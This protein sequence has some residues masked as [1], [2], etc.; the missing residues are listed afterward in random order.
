[1]IYFKKVILSSYTTLQIETALRKYALK[2]KMPLDMDFSSIDIGT[3][4]YFL[5]YQGKNSLTFTRIRTRFEFLLPKIIVK[6][7]VNVNNSEAYYKLRLTLISTMVFVAYFAIL[8]LSISLLIAGTSTID[9]LT[10]PFVLCGIYILLFL[11][12][13]KLTTSRI[14]K[15]IKNYVMQSS[16]IA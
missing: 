14:N 10:A 3:D 11:L 1:M 9:N 4:K 16:P 5:G 6:I 2:R 13:F 15:A 7:P 12:E 8:M